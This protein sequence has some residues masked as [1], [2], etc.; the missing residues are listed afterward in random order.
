MCKLGWIYILGQFKYLVGLELSNRKLE[1]RPGM[2]CMQFDDLIGPN[3][4][5]KKKKNTN[6]AGWGSEFNSGSRIWIE[7]QF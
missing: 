5:K 3:K 6:G 2:Q 7:T 1:F 4:L